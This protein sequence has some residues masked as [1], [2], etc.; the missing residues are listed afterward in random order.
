VDTLNQI[1]TMVKNWF[2]NPSSNCSKH[3]DLIGFLIIEF[4]LAKN[5]FDLIEKSYYFEHLELDND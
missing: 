2:D 5:N 4:S 3:K 1:I